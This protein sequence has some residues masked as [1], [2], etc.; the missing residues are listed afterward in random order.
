MAATPLNSRFIADLLIGR[1]LFPGTGVHLSKSKIPE[2][3]VILR[4]SI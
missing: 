2:A 4:M 3:S 1:N